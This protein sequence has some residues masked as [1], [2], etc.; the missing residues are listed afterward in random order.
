[1]LVSPALLV[2]WYR[3]RNPRRTGNPERKHRSHV[4]AA[5]HLT[6]PSG[7]TTRPCD[8]IYPC[9]IPP[10]FKIPRYTRARI[11][12]S[13]RDQLLWPC[14]RTPVALSSRS[15]SQSELHA[16]HWTCECTC[17]CEVR[18]P[19]TLDRSGLLRGHNRDLCI[20]SSSRMTGIRSTLYQPSWSSS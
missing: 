5:F 11:P 19:L 1:M 13:L 17:S 2:P 6:R 10:H 9:L 14:I 12:F 16:S 20:N 8:Q 15:C 4:V 3:M 7:Y 18:T